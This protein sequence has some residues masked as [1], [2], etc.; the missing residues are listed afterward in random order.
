MTTYRV[1][2]RSTPARTE[3]VEADSPRGAAF[4]VLSA[5]PAAV[6]ECGGGSGPEGQFDFY[7]LDPPLVAVWREPVSV[8]ESPVRAEE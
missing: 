6:R 1:E 5:M 2:I 3:Y 8:E 4:K 7:A